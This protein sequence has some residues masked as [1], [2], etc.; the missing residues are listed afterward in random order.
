MM[1]IQHKF[2]DVIPESLEDGVIYISIPYATAVHKCI[3]GCGNEV[4]TPFSPT[5]WKLIFNGKS[6]SLSPSI[7]NW[8]FLCKS[9]YW[10]VRN[11]VK[12]ARKWEEW[13]IEEGRKIDKINKMIYR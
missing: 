6:V 11:K 13:E 3:C 4:V 7:G 5:D 10:I 1:R 9:H 2:V 8:N 12:F